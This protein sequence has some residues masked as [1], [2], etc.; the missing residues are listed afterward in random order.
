MTKK[1]IVLL[2]LSLTMLFFAAETHG[3]QV[4]TAAQANGTWREVSSKPAGVTTELWIWSLG[5]QKLKVEF[6][7][8]N[9]AKQFSNTATDTALIEG[10]AATFRPAD[11][12]TDETHPCVM[13]LKF[14]ADKLI[15][16]EKGECG[17]GAASVRRGHTKGLAPKSQNSTSSN[18][19]LFQ[20]ARFRD[21]LD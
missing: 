15:V 2:T 13:T 3:Q 5:K 10:T 19:D 21:L 9:A 4:V 18:S 11:N 14:V 1:I 16:T 6:V 8:N 7:G 12:Q 17:W 20:L